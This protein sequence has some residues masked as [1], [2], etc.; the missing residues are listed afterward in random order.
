MAVVRKTLGASA[1]C[2]LAM[3]CIG[4]AQ[5]VQLTESAYSHSLTVKFPGYTGIETLSNFPVLVRLP[6]G[7]DYASCQAGGAD[8]RFAGAD[9]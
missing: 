6:A 9:G 1:L 5:A 7:F 8:L 3:S 4:E 2:A